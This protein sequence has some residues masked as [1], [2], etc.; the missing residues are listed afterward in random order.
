MEDRPGKPGVNRLIVLLLIAVLVF[1][2]Y[3]NALQGEFLH[4]DDRSYVLSNLHVHHITLENILW[5]LTSAYQSNWHPMTWLSH[6]IDYEIWGDNVFGHHLASLL[7]HIANGFLLFL[8][9]SSILKTAGFRTKSVHASEAGDIFFASAIISLI[10][11]LHPLRVE[12]VAWIAERKDVL[13]GFFFLLAIY[14]YLLYLEKKEKKYRR[15][16]L[17]SFILAVMSKSMA[18]SLPLVLL[19]LDYYPYQ[20][21]QELS[22]LSRLVYLCKEKIFF[23]L[24]MI[25]VV[26]ITIATQSSEGSV[27]TLEVYPLVQRVLNGAN[28]FLVYP[29]Q[30]LYPVQLSPF[31][32]FPAY[33]TGGFLLGWL[34]LITCLGI[35]LLF[36]FLAL[37]K[38]IKAP[39]TAFLAYLFMAAPILGIIQ[40]GDQA[41]ADRYSYLPT[42]PVLLLLIAIAIKVLFYICKK[43]TL[44]IIIPAVLII[45]VIASYMQ[46]GYWQ[47]DR[48]LWTRVVDLYPA[49]V[50]KAHLNL[51]NTYFEDGDLATAEQHYTIA[52]QLQPGNTVCLLN[53]N[54]IYEKTNR[55]SYAIQQWKTLLRQQ[56]DNPWLWL[57]YGDFHL[58]QKNKQAA[59][60]AYAIALGKARDAAEIKMELVKRGVVVEKRK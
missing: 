56:P 38:N 29:F 60:E 20:R 59:L 26:V 2:A 47:N 8:I 35:L 17:A 14:L 51:G 1:L 4:W 46:S 10:F 21:A 6:S 7:W 32:P 49:K 43:I 12:S 31:Y 19:I 15:L 9:S 25:A 50:P 16:T 24:I 18:L 23:F 37:K 27:R 13:S 41:H 33:I 28:S 52:C 42:I 5:M 44:F 22:W 40:V 3:S 53:L 58:R 36:L 45:L 57:E 34:P 39:L 30:L 55:I 11:A 54:Q 48:V